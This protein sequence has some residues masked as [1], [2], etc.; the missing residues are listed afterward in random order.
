M[1]KNRTIY[2]KSDIVWVLAKE[3]AELNG[4]TISSVIESALGSYV[5]ANK[6]QADDL[7]IARANGKSQYDI[8]WKRKS[9]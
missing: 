9:L 5:A 7:R 8:P 4:T 2:I 1:S 6:S 3:I